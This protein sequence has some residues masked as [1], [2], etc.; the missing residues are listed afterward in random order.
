[1]NVGQAFLCHAKNNQLQFSRKPAMVAWQIKFN[2]DFAA[3]R[4]CID[5]PLQRGGQAGFI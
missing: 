1:M 2:G 3:L 5:I 4:K